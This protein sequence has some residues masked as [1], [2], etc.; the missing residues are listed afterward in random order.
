MN[1]LLELTVLIYCKSRLWPS[2]VPSVE[3]QLSAMEAVCIW[4]VPDATFNGVGYVRVNGLGIVWLAI[5]SL[6][7]R[8]R[9]FHSLQIQNFVKLLYGL[10]G[11]T[12]FTKF[13]VNLQ[14]CWIC[15]SKWTRDC[16]ASHWFTWF[17]F[18]V[19][20]FLTN[21]KFCQT[22]VWTIRIN[23]FHEVFSQFTMVLD[24]SE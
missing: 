18:P 21:S 6:D 16:M 12:N 2:P 14:W 7:F 17:P 8:F 19:I 1:G 20:S 5:G 22:V 23:Q 13:L 15:Q 9:S 11:S 24:M 4:S 3:V 10:L